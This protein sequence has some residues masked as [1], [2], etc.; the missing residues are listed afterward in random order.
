MSA[1]DSVLVVSSVPVR[2]CVSVAVCVKVGGGVTV[3]V[4]VADNDVESDGDS[5]VSVTA[6]VSDSVRVVLSVGVEERDC[7]RPDG[8]SERVVVR[9]SVFVKDGE[10]PE[11]DADVV[12]DAERDSVAVMMSD[13][14][15]DAVDDC[16]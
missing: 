6:N 2:D 11:M 8:V 3:Y 16:V 4:T 9:V 1:T 5:A 14:D 12:S 13:A 15:G 7:V 10:P